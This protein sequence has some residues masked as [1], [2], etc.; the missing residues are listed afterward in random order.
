MI[1]SIEILF[2]FFNVYTTSVIAESLSTILVSKP[3]GVLSKAVKAAQQILG[4][5]L[6]TN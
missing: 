4:T 1:V 3:F 2:E 5:S 6:S